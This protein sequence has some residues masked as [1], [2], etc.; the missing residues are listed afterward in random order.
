MQEIAQQ[1]KQRK[2][3]VGTSQVFQRIAKPFREQFKYVVQCRKVMGVLQ[4]NTVI[5]GQSAVVNDDGTIQAASV[6]T[7]HWIHKPSLYQLYDTYAKVLRVNED[8][9]GQQFWRK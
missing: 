4:C 8:R 5:D 9:Y 3:I 2:H 7:Y 1:R 6:K